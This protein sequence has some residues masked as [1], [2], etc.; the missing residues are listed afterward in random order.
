M[1]R[2][3][4]GGAIKLKATLLGEKGKE[5]DAVFPV[6]ITLIDGEEKRTFY[7]VLGRELSFDLD[8]PRVATLR[9]YRIEGARGDQR[10]DSCG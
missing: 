4:D 7:R 2:A 8:L 1:V 10:Q 5:F 9:T 6:C 3:G